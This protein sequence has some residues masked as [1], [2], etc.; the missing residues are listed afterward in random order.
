M[1]TKQQRTSPL[2]KPAAPCNVTLELFG[3]GMSPIHRAGLGG[4]VATLRWIERAA[5]SGHMR[6]KDLPGGPWL[7]DRPPWSI[8]PQEVILDFGKPERAAEFLERLFRIAFGTQ[9]GV[10][11][12]PGQYPE[13]EP[14]FAVRIQLQQGITLTFLQHGK[15]RTLAKTESVHSYQPEDD[16]KPPVLLTYKECSWYKHQNGWEDVIDK[17]LG[18]MAAKGVE[19]V[20]P[21]N[22]GAVVRHN[23]FAAQTKIEERPEQIIPLYFAL[24]GCLALSVNRGT[25]VL[26]VPE[27]T[28]L[29]EFARIR[30]LMTP[31]T[32]RECQIV[33]AGDAALQAH[34]RVHA[35][36]QIIFH[37]LPGC[38]ATTFR[39]TP[40]ASQQKSRVHAMTVLPGGNLCLERF[41]VALDELPARLVQRAVT[42]THK[43]KGKRPKNAEPP[44]SFWVNS[45][46]RPLVADNLAQGRPWYRD[47]VSLMTKI[48]AVSRRPLRDKLFFEKEGLHK[49]IENQTMWKDRGESSV[50]Q[51]VHEALRRRLG[52][53]AEENKGKASA[54]KSRM[55][56]EFERWRLAFAGAKTSTQFRYS[57]CDLFSRAGVSQV[58]QSEWRQLLPM[59]SDQNWQLTRDLALLGLASYAGTGA[60]DVRK[61][62]SETE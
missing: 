37:D 16:D 32:D 39:P 14:S 21:M 46:V 49:M 58:L 57:L 20:G 47:F 6:K 56:S 12:L 41:A 52:K 11:Y 53:I 27:V 40:W 48:D 9:G 3:P 44:E 43:G 30:P 5:G 33:S 54:M 34:V 25:G 31:Q 28:D 55:N 60:K 62:D 23:A 19:V 8:T 59:L 61:S 51:A 24:V 38:H 10:I 50:V 4:L 36:A 35:T 45:V 42:E 15:S 1:A 17:R 22:P 26:V 18:R 2:S 13:P 7:A 29:V